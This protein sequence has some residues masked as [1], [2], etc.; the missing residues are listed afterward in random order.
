M[1]AVPKKIAIFILPALLALGIFFCGA[2][3]LSRIPAY[4]DTISTKVSYPSSYD[5][6]IF[7]SVLKKHVRHGLVDYAALKN[8]PELSAAYQDLKQTS[9][10][11]LQ[12]KLEQLSFWINAYNLLTIKCITDR[13]PITELRA[14]S[15][16]R[17]FNVGGKLHSLVQIKEEILPELIK[18]S[19]WRAI[20]LICDGQI[21]A[22]E[23]ADHAYSPAKLSDE[24]PIAMRRFVLSK[25]N[26]KIDEKFKTFSIS[27]F[28]KWN[29]KYIDEVYPSPFDMV[30]SLLTRKVDLDSAYRNYGMPYDFQINDLAWLKKM[31]IDEAKFE[32]GSASKT[33]NQP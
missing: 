10:E 27:P 29:L 20:F 11:K 19:D 16:K 5:F 28:Y 33:N 18:S 24:F 4:L 22:P 25:A 13:Y 14:D 6:R 21:S 32:N 2:S 12:G 3:L 31:G 17:N 15:S 1:K 30:N 7:D 23:I 9:P 8:S 26:Y